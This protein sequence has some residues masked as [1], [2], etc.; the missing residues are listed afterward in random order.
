MLC[1]ALLVVTIK[2][3]LNTEACTADTALEVLLL[4][5]HKPVLIS[6]HFISH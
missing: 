1:A 6:Q 3:G 4:G 5:M 2:V